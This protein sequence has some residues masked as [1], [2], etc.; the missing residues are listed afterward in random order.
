VSRRLRS[1]GCPPRSSP[2]NFGE[3]K[4]GQS[5]P[6]THKQTIT[7][8]SHSLPQGDSQAASEVF[9]EDGILEDLTSPVSE[10]E[11]ELPRTPWHRPTRGRWGCSPGRYRAVTVLPA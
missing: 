1:C 9:A 7:A 8:L 4:V 6:A 3:S 11:A 5:V 10:I 2:I